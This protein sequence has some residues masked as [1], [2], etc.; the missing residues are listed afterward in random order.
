LTPHAGFGRLLDQFESE[1]SPEPAIIAVVDSLLEES[2]L[3][4][5]DDSGRLKTSANPVG[6]MPG[7]AAVTFL[8]GAIGKQR[9]MIGPTRFAKAETATEAVNPGSGVRLAQLI[10]NLAAEAEWPGGSLPWIISDHNG[11]SVRSQVW[12]SAFHRLCA[13]EPRF[14]LTTSWYPAQ[15][16]GDTGQANSAIA[17]VLAFAAWH[18][19]YAPTDECCIVSSSQDC[20]R[21][22]LIMRRLV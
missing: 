21:S 20:E 17:A 18:R 1:Y 6:L 16:F 9:A 2:Q 10:Q 3:L 11:E 5:L 4:A 12:G 14:H 15:S 19:G 7:E 13:G 22:A 8:V